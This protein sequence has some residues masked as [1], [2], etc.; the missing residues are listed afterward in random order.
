MVDPKRAGV[1]ESD[2]TAATANCHELRVAEVI[3]ETHDSCS[4]VFDIPERLKA[5]FRY[6]AGQF[7]SFKI[8]FDGMVLVRSY[9][10]SSSP[11]TDTDV[12]VTVKRVEEGRISNWLND[13]LR[14]GDSLMVVPP[15]GLFVLGDQ[16]RG[17]VLFAGGSG[18]TPVI[19]L[20]KSALATTGRS[21]R[22]VYSN[23]DER[24]T[25]IVE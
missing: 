9:S 20:I 13:Q 24:S 23:R 15:G 1:A 11:D 12:K 10:L 18:I 19:S 5:L 6:K 8:P 25:R 4:I 22:L 7:L 16:A 2:W 14:A 3:V 21:V 17:I